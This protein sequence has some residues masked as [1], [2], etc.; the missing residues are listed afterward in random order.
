M[1]TKTIYPVEISISLYKDHYL[2]QIKPKDLVKGKLRELG[3]RSW[4]KLM[5]IEVKL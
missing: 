3:T 2:I 1:T 5:F 4:K